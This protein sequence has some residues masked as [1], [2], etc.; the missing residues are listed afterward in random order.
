MKVS[1]RDASNRKIQNQSLKKILHMSKTTLS[2]GLLMETS[3]W[4]AEERIEYS[5][6]M[7]IHSIINSNKER[8]S[9]EIILEQ[10]KKGMPNTLYERAKEIEESIGINID[11]TGKMKNQHVIEK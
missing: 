8:I 4:P 10:R 6:L 11:Q 2:T 3:I 1:K 9:Q 7:L 5:T